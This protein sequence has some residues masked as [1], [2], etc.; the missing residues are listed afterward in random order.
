M[1]EFEIFERLKSVFINMADEESQRLFIYKL[2]YA[3]DRDSVPFDWY[4]PPPPPYKRE[5]AMGIT[6]GQ[7]LYMTEPL[8]ITTGGFLTIQ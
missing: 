2:R 3:L 8:M 6:F 4:L 7:N 5:S 1:T